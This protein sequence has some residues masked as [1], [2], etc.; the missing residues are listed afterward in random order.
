MMADE[1]NIN[2]ET[3]HQI[4][5]EDLRKRKMSAKFAPTQT[6]GQAKTALKGERCQDGEDIKKNVT[7][8][9]NAVPLEAISVSVQKLFK[10]CNKCIQVGGAYF[11][12]R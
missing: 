1:L 10:R 5:R 3:I 4:L 11:E 7:A 9:R 12:F 6:Q 2:K 8:E